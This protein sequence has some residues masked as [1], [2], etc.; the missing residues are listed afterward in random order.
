M[1]ARR[2][3]ARASRHDLPVRGV[4]AA[5]G[6]AVPGEVRLLAVVHLLH[7]AQ[8]ARRSSTEYFTELTQTDVREYMRPE[9]VREHA[10]HPARVPAARRASGVPGAA[11]AGGDARRQLRH[12]QRLRAGENVPVRAGSEEYLDSE[13]YQIRPRD[14]EQPGSLAELIAPHQRDPP[15]RIRRCSATGACASTRP[16]TRSCICYS[17]RSDGRAAT[18]SS[19]SC[20]L[21]SAGHAARVRPAAAGRLGPDAGRHRRG[22]GPASGERYFWRGE[23]NYVRLDP[24]GRVAHILHVQLPRPLSET[25]LRAW[26]DGAWRGT[27]CHANAEL[28]ATDHEPRYGSS[29][30]LTH[31]RTRRPTLV[32]GRRHLP[33][34]RPRLFRQHERRRRRLRRPDAEAGLPAGA[35]RQLRCGCCRS[36]RRRC[37]TTA[38]TSRTTRTSIRAT[39]RWPTST[40]S[41]R[42]RTAGTSASSPSW[43]STTPRISTPGS[44]RRGGR[45]PDRPSANSTSGATRTRSTRACGSS[46]PTPRLELELGRHGQGVLLAPVLSPPAGPELRQSRRSSRR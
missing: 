17:K 43:S 16:T 42:R 10:G 23:W 26:I 6:D 32:Q 39:A 37:E 28:R 3:Q 4:H 22:R 1:G 44:R 33:G 27:R 35:R 8:H 46:S 19:W 7:L 12:L 18:W 11:R 25:R 9:P 20:N 38:T 14:F 21:D 15:R 45:R 13:K 41:S 31:D 5:E 34:A 24:P 2:D 30:G 29:D 36:I 40:G